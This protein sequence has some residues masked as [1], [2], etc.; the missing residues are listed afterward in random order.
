MVTNP[1]QKMN[2]TATQAVIV[3]ESKHFP[4]QIAEVTTTE[5]EKE[6][7]EFKVVMGN[8]LLSEKVFADKVKA[9]KYIASRP[10][11]LITNMVCLTIKNAFDYEKSKS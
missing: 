4:F 5:N 2:Q 1:S 7:K 9:E 10:W 11:D 8:A 3:H 6:T